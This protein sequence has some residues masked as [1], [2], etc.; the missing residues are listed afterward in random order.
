MISQKKYLMTPKK[1]NTVMLTILFLMTLEALFGIIG[2]F[3]QHRISE[4]IAIFLFWFM[5]L[6]TFTIMIWMLS[7]MTLTYNHIAIVFLFCTQFAFIILA[8]LKK[9][10]TNHYM[11]TPSENT[12]SDFVFFVMWL[13]LVE[14]VFAML[15]ILILLLQIYSKNEKIEMLARECDLCKKP[16]QHCEGHISNYPYVSKTEDIM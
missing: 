11:Y 13:L 8:F 15:A 12:Y 9:H 2:L 10:L 4:F 7:S 1:D 5:L 16:L 14:I 3:L 6:T